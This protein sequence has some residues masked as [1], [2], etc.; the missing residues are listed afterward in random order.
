MR[1]AVVTGSSSGIG[2]AIARRLLGSGWRGAGPGRAPPGV[3]GAGFEAIPVDLTGA[4][5][6]AGAFGRL[7]DVSAIVHAAGILRVASLGKLDASDSERMWR[8][9]VCCATALADAMPPKLP[10]GGRIVLIGSI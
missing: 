3:A 9:H 7:E 4:A 5:A 10:D 6:R 1:H 8:L 2:E